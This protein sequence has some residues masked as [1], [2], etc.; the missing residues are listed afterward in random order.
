MIDKVIVT[1]INPDQPGV[2][3]TL[4]SIVASGGGNI[5]EV[6]STRDTSANLF[7]TRMEIE[8][9]DKTLLTQHLGKLEGTF[10]ITPADDT[11][12]RAAILCSNTLHTTSAIIN[13]TNRNNINIEIA[14]IISDKDVAGPLAQQHSIKFIRLP[15]S[16]DYRQ[17]Q[18]QRLHDTLNELDV[19]LVILS[20]YMRILPAYITKHWYGKMINIHHALLPAF[21]GSKPYEKAFSAGVKIIGATAHYVTEH[22]DQGPIIAQQVVA[23]SYQDNCA[24][25]TRRGESVE[26]QVLLD[27]I[28]SHLAKKVFLLEGRTVVF[29]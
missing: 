4:A 20:R 25:L 27:A 13:A 10:T 9:A 7:L 2:L 5:T 6:T 19:D 26:S 11:P 24:G 14:A 15:I 8:G 21:P 28:T 12:V 3:S 1:A 23:T 17:A 16:K 18:E 29:P 22:L